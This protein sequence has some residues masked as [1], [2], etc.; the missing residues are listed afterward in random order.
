MDDS[1]RMNEQQ[2]SVTAPPSGSMIGLVLR[3]AVGGVMMGLANL[4]P[5][6]SGGTML[7][8]TGVYKA[9]IEA[10]AEVST[11]RFRARSVV[12]LG[13]V[14]LPAIAAI[15]LL[16]G[17]MVELVTGRPLVMFSLFIGLTLGG[18]PLLKKMLG[19]AT[20][21]AWVACGVMFAGMAGLA[22]VQSFGEAG[23]VNR[24]GF[25]FMLIAGLV[26]SSAMILPGVSGGYMFLLLGVYVP[27]LKG[28]DALKD[29]EEMGAR[30]EVLT[31]VVL[32]VGIGVV[33]GVVVVS[34]VLKVMLARCE[35][36]TLGALMGLLLG[37]VVGLWPFQERVPAEE[38]ARVKGQVVEVVEG[39]MVYAETG[40]AVEAEDLPSRPRQPE[41]AGEIGWSV[42]LIL[43]GFGATM[44]LARIG[45][46]GERGAD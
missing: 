29:A 43:V 10:I 9:F 20:A 13:A 3:G 2:N 17:V 11:L 45:G 7:V 42:G 6:I 32:P 4:V 26:A 8:A 5:G 31:G 30:V 46:S 25:V 24:E 39:A 35:K 22:Y 12:T 1:G 33:V 41:G 36:A 44:G 18:V 21:S 15:A 14:V 16:S 27:I 38:V 34:N 19:K 40:E 37:A 23:G 28:I